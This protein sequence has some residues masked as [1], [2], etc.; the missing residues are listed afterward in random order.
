MPI[1]I[2]VHH[3][4]PALAELEALAGLYREAFC[5]PPWNE[6]EADVA[7]FIERLRTTVHRPGFAAIVAEGDGRPVGFATAW[8]TLAPFPTDRRYGDVLSKLGPDRVAD[9]L[10]GTQQIDELAVSPRA[11]GQGIGP[12]L[13]ATMTGLDEGRGT[14]LLISTRSPV[15]V[16]FYRRCGWHQ[17]TDVRG[18][19][20]D[21]VVFLSPHHPRE[22]ALALQVT[23]SVEGEGR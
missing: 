1:D 14:W 21:I 8:R 12:R 13:P 9:W 3:G 22:G 2:T 16:P 23:G 5:A 18:D 11:Q 17:V 19:A 4:P 7:A 15:T 10:I 20:E 6:D